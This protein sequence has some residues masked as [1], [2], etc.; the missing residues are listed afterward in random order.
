MA[1]ICSW[2]MKIVGSNAESVKKMIE[3]LDHKYGT[4]GIHA[5]CTEAWTCEEVKRVGLKNV[6]TAEMGGDC[7]WS[8]SSSMMC[9]GGPDYPECHSLPQLCKE[10]GVGIHAYSEEPGMGFEEQIIIDADGSVQVDDSVEMMEYWWDREQSIDDF[11]K[12]YDTHFTEEDFNGEDYVK[13][14]GYGSWDF[15]EDNELADLLRKG[16]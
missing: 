3:A 11:N 15:L 2:S 9:G 6:F 5:A 12:E 13:V 4:P 16:E 14:G 8:M 7:K 10:L 1:N